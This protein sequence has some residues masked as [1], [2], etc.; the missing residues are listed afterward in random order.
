[1]KSLEERYS[2]FEF[3]VIG[4]FPEQEKKILLVKAEPIE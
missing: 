1:M 2:G 4:W 3:K